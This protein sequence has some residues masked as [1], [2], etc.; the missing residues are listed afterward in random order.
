M[1]TGFAQNVRMLLAD[2][3]RLAANAARRLGGNRTELTRGV[4]SP[5]DLCK[6][7]PSAPPLWQFKAREIDHDREQKLLEFRDATLELDGWPVFYTPY[8]SAPGPIRKA[9][10]RLSDARASATPTRTASTSRFRIIGRST[11]TRI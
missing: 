2:R 7:N 5:C 8:I 11:S 6:D 1:N 10:Q 4:Y 9:G 3:S